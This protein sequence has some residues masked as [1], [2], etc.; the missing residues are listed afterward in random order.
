MKQLVLLPKIKIKISGTVKMANR[1]AFFFFFKEFKSMQ[2][3]QLNS[4]SAFL[5]F[6][7]Y[8]QFLLCQPFIRGLLSFLWF[9]KSLLH[10]DF[11]AHFLRANYESVPLFFNTSELNTCN[12][13]ALVHGC[14]Q[15][16][17]VAISVKVLISWDCV[18]LTPFFKKKKNHL[19]YV[20]FVFDSSLRQRRTGRQF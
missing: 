3:W 4:K 6:F 7:P 10:G 2:L 20:A 17:I 11:L 16:E 8:L 12:T 15:C 14:K 13:S 9:V 1:I 18:R 19:I 5:S